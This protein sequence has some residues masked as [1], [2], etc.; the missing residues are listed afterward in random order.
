VLIGRNA[1]V[2]VNGKLPPGVALVVQHLYRPR[3]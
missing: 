1:P 3:L 2:Q